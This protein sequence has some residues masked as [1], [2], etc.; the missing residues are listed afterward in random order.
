MLRSIKDLHGCTVSA[1]D[2]DIGTVD[3]VYFDVDLH[4]IL[5]R[6]LH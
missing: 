1:I 6:D 4:G 3:Q 5:T 2:G